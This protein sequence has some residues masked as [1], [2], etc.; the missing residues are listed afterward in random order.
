M[1]F[2]KLFKLLDRFLKIASRVDAWWITP[3]G[4]IIDVDDGQNHIDIARRFVDQSKVDKMTEDEVITDFVDQGAIRIRKYN[5]LFVSV[6]VLTPKTLDNLKNF[7]KEKE[8][9]DDEYVLFDMLPGR[10]SKVVGADVV[11]KFGRW[12]E[13]R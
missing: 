8:I 13:N 2:T 6:S 11:K 1:N 5:D 12:G 4:N 10:K 9:S 3:D 7:L